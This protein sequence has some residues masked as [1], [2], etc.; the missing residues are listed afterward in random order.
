MWPKTRPVYFQ[1]FGLLTAGGVVEQHNVREM[2]QQIMP[3]YPP[4][5]FIP[6]K[7]PRALP[8]SSRISCFADCKYKSL[9]PPAIT[10][11]PP[12]WQLMVHVRVYYFWTEHVLYCSVGMSRCSLKCRIL[13]T[14]GILVLHL[15][16]CWLPV[17]CSKVKVITI[18]FSWLHFLY[19]V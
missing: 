12:S 14:H 4:K 17:F 10:D 11:K 18:Y 2:K 16:I 1:C 5:H 9:L 3:I 19:N 8:I 6:E 13:C 7:H 15:P